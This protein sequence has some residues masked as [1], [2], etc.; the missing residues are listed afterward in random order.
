MIGDAGVLIRAFGTGVVLLVLGKGADVHE[1]AAD[2]FAGLA[3]RAVLRR[4]RPE[5]AADDDGCLGVGFKGLQ[6]RG[7]LRLVVGLGLGRLQR[8]DVFADAEDDE[9][10]FEGRR[11]GELAGDVITHMRAFEVGDVLDEDFGLGAMFGGKGLGHEMDVVLV[12][13]RRG[14]AP[15]PMPIDVGLRSVLRDAI[16]DEEDLL[17]LSLG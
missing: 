2:G 13:G 4:V 3:H 11:I 1:R 7:D 15:V 6:Q 16:A 14:H 12:F 17:G 8:G 9:V 5:A 10:G